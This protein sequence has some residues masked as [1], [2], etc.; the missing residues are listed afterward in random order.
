MTA[1]GLHGLDRAA[2]AS[3]HSV[4]VCDL[5]PEGPARSSLRILVLDSAGRVLALETVNAEGARPVPVRIAQLTAMSVLGTGD[6]EVDP[7]SWVEEPGSP[8]RM[9]GSLR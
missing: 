8:W 7:E 9:R 3:A 6:L 4:E 2:L 1:L 5:D